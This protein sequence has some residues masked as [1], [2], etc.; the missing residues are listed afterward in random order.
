MDYVN[1]TIPM[2]PQAPLWEAADHIS[3]SSTKYSGT[4][5]YILQIINYTKTNCIK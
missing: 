1:P 5:T 2:G 3:S 4:L